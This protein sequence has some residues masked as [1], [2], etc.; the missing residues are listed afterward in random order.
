M[1]LRGD[2][3]SFK[4]KSQLHNFLHDN[5]DCYWSYNTGN[6]LSSVGQL[7]L[8]TTVGQAVGINCHE[9]RGPRKTYNLLHY[10]ED[11]TV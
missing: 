1:E 2:Q 11:S 7:Q 8:V 10:Q 5:L 6:S 9:T 3:D 4:F